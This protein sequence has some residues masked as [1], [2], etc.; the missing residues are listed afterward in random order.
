MDS[1]SPHDMPCLSVQ[2]GGARASSV[3]VHRV[4]PDRVAQFLELQRGLTEAARAFPGYQATDVYPPAEPQQSE[5]V[6]VV[7]FDGPQ[8]LQRWLDSPARAAWLEKRRNEL[9]DFRLK[10]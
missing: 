7:H 10:T 3:I 9:G 5:W 2:A 1:S 4:P 8:A 6:V